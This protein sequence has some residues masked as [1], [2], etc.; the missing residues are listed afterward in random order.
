[1]TNEVF[2]F[3]MVRLFDVVAASLTCGTIV[4][5]DGSAALNASVLFSLATYDT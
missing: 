5:T 3:A 2:L 1:M 4:N